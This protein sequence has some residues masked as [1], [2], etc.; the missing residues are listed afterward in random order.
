[1]AIFLIFAPLMGGVQ[2]IAFILLI[3][4]RQGMVVCIEDGGRDSKPIFVIHDNLF[5]PTN[6]HHLRVC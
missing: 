2:S 5:R 3:G 4:M 1:M 6:I